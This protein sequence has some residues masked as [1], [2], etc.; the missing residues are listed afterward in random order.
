MFINIRE[1]QK[2]KMH[3][4]CSISRCVV[5]RVREVQTKAVEKMETRIVFS[6]L[7]FSEN[8]SAYVI[9]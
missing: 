7:L 4:Y 8:R 5:L 2:K 6:K 9:M 3:I 1:Q